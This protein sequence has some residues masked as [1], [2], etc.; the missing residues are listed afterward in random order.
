MSTFLLPISLM[1]Q[2]TAWTYL[3]K[4]DRN[5]VSLIPIEN[6]HSS[7]GHSFSFIAKSFMQDKNLNKFHSINGASK[8]K[9]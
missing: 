5:S 9:T 4:I 3:K 6:Y 8:K 1:K 2:H 7:Q